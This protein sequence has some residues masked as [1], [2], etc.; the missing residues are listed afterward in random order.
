MKVGIV[1]DIHGNIHAL[2]SVETKLSELN[3][4]EVW[5]LGDMVG[6][7]AFPNE[8]LNWVRENCSRVLLGN[9]ELALLGF[10]DLE[11]LNTYAQTVIKWSLERISEEN[12]EFLKNLNI[13]ELLGCCQL[14]HD[15]PVS[16]G[17][18]DYILTKNEAF[19]ALLSQKREICFF[20]HTHIPKAYRLL[21]SLIDEISTREVNIT[22]GRY[23]LNPG[24][25]GQPR[26]RDPRASFGIYDTE[27]EKFSV[28]RVEYPVKTAAREILRAGL[29]EFLAARLIVGV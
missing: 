29:P 17:S 10:V 25:V 3:V 23:L 9:H 15:T 8:C 13:Q 19:K 2:M 5:C 14:V 26:D 11:L 27:R 21:S 1:S 6:Y 4:D 20:G 28:F 22:G 7:G 18:M 12:L 24:S 16:P